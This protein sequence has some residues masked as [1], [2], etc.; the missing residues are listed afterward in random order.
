LS[1]THDKKG[2]YYMQKPTFQVKV[3]D[4]TDNHGRIVIGPLEKG[5]GNT[6]GN[7]LRRV[8]LSELKGASITKIKIDGV[9][10]KF[11]TLEGMGEDII[12]LVLNVKQVK[13]AYEGEEPVMARLEAKGPG[14]VKAGEIVA[15]ATVKVVNKDMVIANLSKGAKLNMDIEISSGYGYSPADERVANVIGEIPVDALYSPVERVAYRVESTRVGRR[16]DFD[17]LILDIDTDGSQL[18]EDVLKTAADIL[19]SYF[20]QVSNPTEVMPEKEKAS[21]MA[22]E[23]EEYQLSV[24]ELGLPTRIAN[25]LKNGGYKTVRD[26]AS[27]DMSELKKVKNLGAKSLDS[28]LDILKDKGVEIEG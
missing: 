4:Q 21:S 11:S 1:I 8:L 20:N 7:A 24:E 13:V 28:I 26:L 18:P 12:D 3:E 19:T 22:D 14:P 2:D 16:T 15:P 6:L 5:F 10:H 9:N 17:S 23:P 25:A 27:A